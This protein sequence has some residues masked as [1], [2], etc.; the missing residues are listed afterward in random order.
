M[1]LR[2]QLPN[3]LSSLRLALVPA[4]LALAWNEKPVAFL[5]LFAFSL[6]TDLV[7]GHLARR[8]KADS[9]MGAKLDSW[10]DLATYAVFPLCAWWLYRDQVLA[11]AGFVIAAL[12]A[13][14]APTL[15]GL[16]KYRRIT[17]YHTWGAKLCAIFMGAGLLL[18]LGFDVPGLFQGAVVLLLLSAIEEIAITAVLPQWR[19]NVPSIF[20]ALRIA[21]GAA[22]L[23]ALALLGL[24]LGAAAQLPDL[25]PGV[26][27]VE[28]QYGATVAA[29]DVAEGCAGA[30]SGRDLVRLSLITRNDG[31]GDMNIGDPKCPDCKDPKNANAVCG[32]PD[33]ICSPAGGHN[34]AHYNNFLEYEILD[35]NGTTVAIGGKR[36]FCL[37]ET[38]AP[39][40]TTGHTCNNQGLNAGCYDIYPFYLGCQYVDVTNLPNGSYTLRVAVDPLN[41]FAEVSEDN[42]VITAPVEI[43]RAPLEDASL[44]GG[45][46]AMKTG[47]VL[48]IRSKS[49]QVLSLAGSQNDPTLSG[50]AL[51]VVDLVGG[52]QIGFALPAANWKRLGKAEAPKGFVYKAE[53]DDLYPCSA[54]KITRKGVEVKCML[55]GTHTYFDLPAEGDIF[56]RLEVGATPR[57]MCASFGG[58]TKRN[59]DLVLKRIKPPAASCSVVE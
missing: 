45:A 20:S 29:G 21:R 17:S 30:T 44:R 35:P 7:D 25:V 46:L 23:L 16:A 43:A 49:V 57:L 11:Q 5:S 32:N 55:D 53:P 33:F 27:D 54:V 8:W 28:V 38:P 10:G 59:D 36:S 18:F 50:A 34:H 12:I 2:H 3:L 58:K 37:M 47:K 9:V 13:F 4:L 31:P 6:S 56:V 40:C 15:I 14:V 19:A 52:D 22:P 24:P 51:Y 42:N 48:K 39:G 1:D 26:T 41:R